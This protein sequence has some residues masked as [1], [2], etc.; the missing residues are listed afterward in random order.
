VELPINF[1]LDGE[2]IYSKI[3]L[4]S[5]CLHLPIDILGESGWA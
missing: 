3:L 1:Y 5:V 2:I 4:K